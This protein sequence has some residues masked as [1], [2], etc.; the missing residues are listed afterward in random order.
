[1]F[2]DACGAPLQPGQKYCTRCGKTVLVPVV[3]GGG[4]RVTQHVHVLGILWIVYSAFVVI[5]AAVMFAVGSIFFGHFGRFGPP[6]APP[7]FFVG[8]LITGIGVLVAAKGIAGIIAGVGLMHRESWARV[9]AIVL[10]I[11]G[12]LS[13]P[14]GTALGIYTLWVLLSPNADA[15]YKALGQAV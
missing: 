3:A 12:L 13:L 11:I 9:L 7:P 10:G 14:F 4:G 6:G 5:A 15:E 1:M 8:P 2:C